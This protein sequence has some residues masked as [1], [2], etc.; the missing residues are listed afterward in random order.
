MEEIYKKTPV[1]NYETGEF[2]ID[3]NAVAVATGE[4]ALK[5]I[6]IKAQGTERGTYLIYADTENADLNHKYGTDA[7]SIMNRSELPEEVKEAEIKRA[8]REAILYDP[9]VEEVYDITVAKQ[10]G[11]S[12]LA[13]FKVRS[14]FDSNLVVEG[15]QING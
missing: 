11:D 5:Q 4:E 2:V 15:V 10:G 7:I 9:W 6:I 3:S 1:F 12:Y 8:I 14:I 13:S